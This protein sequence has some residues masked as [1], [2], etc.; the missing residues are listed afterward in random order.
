[1]SPGERELA[2]IR[3][4]A[5]ELRSGADDVLEL[6]RETRELIGVAEPGRGGRRRHR[7]SAGGDE[8]DFARRLKTW[9][10]KLRA[11]QKSGDREGALAEAERMAARYPG[12]PEVLRETALQR[13]AAGRTE[14]AIAAWLA[15]IELEPDDWRTRYQLAEILTPLQRYDE[16]LEVLE[17]VAESVPRR[18]LAIVLR[19]AGQAERALGIV[20]SILA[21]IPGDASSWEQRIELLEEMG[22]ADEAAQARLDRDRSAVATPSAADIVELV[23]AERPGDGERYVVNVGCRDGRR[24]DPCYE[25][26]QAGYPGLAIDA[27][28]WPQVHVNL[29]SPEVKKLL[30]TALTPANVVEVLEREG[31]PRRFSLLKID[32]DSYDGIL[33][34]AALEVF[35]PNVIQIEVNPEIPPPLRFSISYDERYRPSGNLGFFGCSVAFVTGVCRPRGYELLR[36][37]WRDAILVREE[38]LPLWEVERPVDERALF[39]AE[40]P[41]PGG[42]RDLGVDSLAWRQ[43]TDPHA[44]LS[45][46]WDACVEASMRRSGEVLPF[47]LSIDRGSSGRDDPV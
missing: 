21:D 22:R 41:R 46:V 28:N 40:E 26:F 19:G 24:E 9:Q 45:A 37:D 23:D 25:L 6:V 11:A 27:A 15:A 36:V 20:D 38:Y 3:A 34:E 17:P 39:L 1:M 30:N 5:G 16:A 33:L 35:E 42:F 29:P 32:I 4:L 12:E 13:L 7:R 44:L 14:P 31:C 47:V 8:E 43:E 18:D 2:E 10:R